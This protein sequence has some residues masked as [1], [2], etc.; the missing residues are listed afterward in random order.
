MFAAAWRSSR[1]P[2]PLSAVAAALRRLLASRPPAAAAAWAPPPAAG[3]AA[4]G[5]AQSPAAAA[6]RRRLCAHAGA[7][8]PGAAAMV[9]SWDNVLDILSTLITAK[10][11]A[12]GRGWRDAHENMPTHL[13]RLGMAESVQ[14]LSVLH[15]AGTKG[16][17]STC[18]MTEAMLRR[19]GYRT[20]LYTS[21]HLVDVR[22]RVR[23]GGALVG[24]EPFS[25]HFWAVYKTLAAVADGHVGMPGYF[26]CV[27]CFF[28]GGRAWAGF[29]GRSRGAPLCRLP[30]L[31]CRA[32]PCACR[33][34]VRERST[35]AKQASH[36]P[37]GPPTRQIPLPATPP[38]PRWGGSG[39][40]PP[41]TAHLLRRAIECSGSTPVAG[42]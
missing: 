21:P 36:P 31:R 12:D 11:R 20:G 1:R 26:R 23:L 9:E 37:G 10:S 16:K 24:R 15:V 40:G 34:C 6:G 39:G 27:F 38:Y 35:H 32:R 18:A 25:E 19:C 2:P 29:R 22:E 5:R 30:A 3:A 33:C 42:A 41:G 4:A 14:T 7:P 8:P 28:A 17:G 13:A